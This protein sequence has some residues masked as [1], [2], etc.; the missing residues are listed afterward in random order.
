MPAYFNLSL[1]FE[2]ENLY[3]DFME[4]FLS[5]WNKRGC[6]IC[7]VIGGQRKIPG[8]K[9]SDG[10]NQNWNRISSWVLQNII[11]MII[12]RYCILSVNI[13]R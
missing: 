6:G 12:N 10:I 1:E 8:M 7:R 5:F 11:L 2:R 4:D 9:S 3:P 13:Q